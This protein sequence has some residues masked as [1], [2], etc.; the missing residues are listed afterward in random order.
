MILVRM[1][2]STMDNPNATFYEGSW[3]IV[4]YIVI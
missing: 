3:Y 4:E 1:T 2:A